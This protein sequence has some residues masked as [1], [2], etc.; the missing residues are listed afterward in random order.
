MRE[1]FDKYISV[2]LKNWTARHKTPLGGRVRLIREIESPE[3]DKSS[4]RWRMWL[5]IKQYLLETEN[6]LD[7]YSDE[8]LWEPLLVN[9]QM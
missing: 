4:L 9:L 1:E 3:P 5:I 8:W 7:L 2:S 6:L